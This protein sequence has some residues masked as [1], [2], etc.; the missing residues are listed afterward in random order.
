M[1]NNQSPSQ[2]IRDLLSKFQ[3]RLSDLEKRQIATEAELAEE[4]QQNAKLLQQMSK[5]GENLSAVINFARLGRLRYPDKT[6][7]E[8]V[9][10]ALLINA[11]S[12]GSNSFGATEAEFSAE[13]KFDVNQRNQRLFIVF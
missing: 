2:A 4:K 10:S 1:N 12:T 11:T 7:I 13:F 6:P 9:R 8:D 5:K 3:A